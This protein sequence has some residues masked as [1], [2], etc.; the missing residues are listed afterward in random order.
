MGYLKGKYMIKKYRHLRKM[1]KFDSKVIVNFH[2]EEEFGPIQT[3]RHRLIA[4]SS[5]MLA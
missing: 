1:E 3:K 5:K 4:S 2:N